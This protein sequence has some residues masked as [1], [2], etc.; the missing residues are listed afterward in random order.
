MEMVV[1]VIVMAIEVDA[2]G[3][4]LSRFPLI[5]LLCEW[6]GFKELGYSLGIRFVG[7]LWFT[8]LLLML[9]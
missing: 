3:R 8:I 4:S 6:V 2:V 5:G 9:L 7:E 1:P